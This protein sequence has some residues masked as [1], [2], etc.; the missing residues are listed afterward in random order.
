MARHQARQ[1]AQRAPAKPSPAPV[2][3]Q[4]EKK[5]TREEHLTKQRE[6]AKKAQAQKDAAAKAGTTAPP[7][8]ASAA[9]LAREAERKKREEKRI[10][11]KTEQE[12][13]R[14]SREENRQKEREAAREAIRLRPERRAAAKPGAAKPD[15]KGGERR[16]GSPV[17]LDGKDGGGGGEGPPAEGCR[18]LPG[19]ATHCKVWARAGECEKNKE[20]MHHQCAESCGQCGKAAPKAAGGVKGAAATVAAAA[21]DRAKYG[22]DAPPGRG[23][24]RKDVPPEPPEQ[25]PSRPVEEPDDG[26]PCSDENELCPSWAAI[27]ECQRN[28]AYMHV[29][30]RK[31]CGFCK[32]GGSE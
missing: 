2:P 8:A 5:K 25:V 26:R 6:M 27:G 31:S 28:S 9:Q 12:E 23:R 15:A 4:E 7:A 30:C 13:L 16:P 29:E 22:S 19:Y 24:G 20:F 11:R 3:T 18:D 21:A 14:K 32:G 17:F 1:R 10:E